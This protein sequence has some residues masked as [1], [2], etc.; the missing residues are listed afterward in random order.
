MTTNN[1]HIPPAPTPD[2]SSQKDGNLLC[3]FLVYSPLIP[4]FLR[5]ADLLESFGSHCVGFK[6]KTKKPP[7]LFSRVHKSAATGSSMLPHFQAEFSLDSP[8]GQ[9]PLE[10][11]Y[12]KEIKQRFPIPCFRAIP[13]KFLTSFLHE[14]SC[15]SPVGF[16]SHIPRFCEPQIPLNTRRR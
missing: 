9:N 14:F 11:S 6:N 12:L 16:G 3:P 7:N 15:P 10:F 1:C 5:G 4:K 13:G 2:S 8:D